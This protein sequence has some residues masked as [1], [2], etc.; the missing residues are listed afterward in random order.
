MRVTPQL[1]LP[2][3]LPQFLVPHIEESVGVHAEG[4]EGVGVE[5]GDGDDEGDGEEPAPVILLNT[6]G[7]TGVPCVE[8]VQLQSPGFVEGQVTPIFKGAQA[9]KLGSEPSVLGVEADIRY[10]VVFVPFGVGILPEA[11]SASVSCLYPP[12]PL[13]ALGSYLASYAFLIASKSPLYFACRAFTLTPWY[14]TNPTA[15]SMAMMEIT[16]KSSMRVKPFDWLRSFR[17]DMI[18]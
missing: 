10:E 16:T 9:A 6:D 13:S 18:L 2:V 8:V 15:E 7:S 14:E 5:A 3:I 11:K 1:S 4:T 17:A 12:W